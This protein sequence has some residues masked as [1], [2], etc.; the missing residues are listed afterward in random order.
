MRVSHS[1]PEQP[2]SHRRAAP[3]KPHHCPQPVASS[4]STSSSVLGKGSSQVWLCSKAA[5]QHHKASL[6][7]STSTQVPVGCARN[8]HIPDV[9]PGTALSAAAKLIPDCCGI[10]ALCSVSSFCSCSSP[11]VAP[12]ALLFPLGWALQAHSLHHASAVQFFQRRSMAN[13]F[14]SG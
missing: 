2:Q 14:L 13:V 9:P 8:A 11:P 10:T 12:T 3:E 1:C 5:P 6:H 7:P 4:S